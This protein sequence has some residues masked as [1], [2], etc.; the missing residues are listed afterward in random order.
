MT[1]RKVVGALLVASPF[2]ALFAAIVIWD[3]IV[4]A[5]GIYAAVAILAGVITWGVALLTS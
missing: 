5:A 1:V 3:G 4:V 2:V